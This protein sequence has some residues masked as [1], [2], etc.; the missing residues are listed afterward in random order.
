M[1]DKSFQDLTYRNTCSEKTLQS[2]SKGFFL[3]FA[4]YLANEAGDDWIRNVFGKLHTDEQRIKCIY[5]SQ[6]TAELVTNFQSNVKEVY[7][8]KNAELSQKKR[9]EGEAF[10]KKNEPTKALLVFCQSVLRAPCNN[11]KCLESTASLSL[12]LWGRSKANMKLQNFS[13]ALVDIQQALKENLPESYKAEAFWN[14]GICY[15]SIGEANKATVSFGL[16]E[17]LLRDNDEKL[18]LLTKEK[19]ETCHIKEK[20]NILTDTPKI[21]GKCNNNL[22]SASDK[23][24]IKKTENM[25]RYIVANEKIITGETLVVESPHAACLLP[26]MF[27]SHC[28]HCFQILKSPFGCYDCASVAFCSVECRDK[29]LS[30]YHRFECKYLDL[31]IG[32]GMSILG[33]TALRMITQN[34]LEKCLEIYDNRDNERVYKLCTN[35]QL[36]PPNDFLQRTLM[37]SFLLRCLQKSNFFGSSNKNVT[38]TET[39]YK[40]GEMLLFN[41]Q[42]LQ[43]NAH[44]I[45]ETRHA[46]SSRIKTS[47]PAYIGVAVYLTAS[48]FNHDCHPA[49]SRH[50]VGKDI[51]LTSTR[52]LEPNELVPENYGPIFSRKSLADRKRSLSSRYWFD[53]QCLACQQNWPTIGQGLEAVSKR[54]RISVP[55]HKETHLAEEM[56]RACFADSGNTWEILIND[57]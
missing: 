2:N 6:K 3:N 40:V 49:L 10:L 27:G 22:P 44:E 12:A 20:E 5:T 42:M 21:Q 39:E 50:F 14:M 34:G 9:L 4:D 25:G 54:L 17:K 53:C 29:A 30:T 51:V 43:F 36:R 13:K 19:Q 32:S 15:A 33:H 26:E 38:P 37:A 46:P 48:L 11:K 7:R 56:L 52:P 41:L 45:Y 23:L 57:K 47:K 35:S 24:S 31:L 16:A 1:S 8:N 28:H 18:H 55:P